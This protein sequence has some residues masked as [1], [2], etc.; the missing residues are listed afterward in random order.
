MKETSVPTVFSLQGGTAQMAYNGY[1]N[2]PHYPPGYEPPR[3]PQQQPVNLAQTSAIP[4]QSPVSQTPTNQYPNGT[5][6][7]HVSTPAF[8]AY[9]VDVGS[10]P[11]RPPAPPIISPPPPRNRK[12][13]SGRKIK[14]EQS[15]GHE[16]TEKQSGSG[17]VSP[18]TKEVSQLPP[19]KSQQ[20]PTG[21]PSHMIQEFTFMDVTI[22]APGQKSS[23]GKKGGDKD[24]KQAGSPPKAVAK[25]RKKQQGMLVDINHVGRDMAL[26]EQ[27]LKRRRVDGDEPI[28]D[29]EDIALQNF[30]IEAPVRTSLSGPSNEGGT[31][32][33]VSMKRPS[34]SEGARS[35]RRDHHAC[36]RCFRNKTKV[37]FLMEEANAKCSRAVDGKPPSKHFPCDYCVSIQGICSNAIAQAKK[38]ESV[39]LSDETH[40]KQ[41]KFKD[42]INSKVEQENL[43][44]RREL[45]GYEKK[46]TD[47][48]RLH[49]AVKAHN[50]TL[51]QNLTSVNA[52]LKGVVQQK[53][54]WQNRAMNLRR[55]IQNVPEDETDMPSVPPSIDFVEVLRIGDDPI[56]GAKYDTSLSRAIA[57]RDSNATSFENQTLETLETM[58]KDIQTYPDVLSAVTKEAPFREYKMPCV[59]MTQL[60]TYVRA[61]FAN[62]HPL[63]PVL[64]QE[65]FLRMYRTWAKDAL[66]DGI[67]SI[68]DAGRPGRAV[69]LIWSVAAL[70]A[71][72]L[73]ETRDR[74]S[75]TENHSA[76]SYSAHLQEALGLYRQCLKLL[77][78][79][80]ETIESMLAYLLVGVFAIQTMDPK[81][82]FRRLQNF[83]TQALS[84]NLSHALKEMRKKSDVSYDYDLWPDVT[85][86]IVIQMV[87]RAWCMF[88]SYLS[89]V[90]LELGLLSNIATDMEIDCVELLPQ[91]IDDEVRTSL[92]LVLTDRY[93]A[94][95]QRKNTVPLHIQAVSRILLPT[96]VLSKSWLVSETHTR[97]P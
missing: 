55:E 92:L 9:Q 96:C 59:D 95:T 16:V 56:P 48:A 60:H 61:Y 64:H 47:Q 5:N 52:I 53:T 51:E 49:E 25:G 63:L 90:A 11:V 71:L 35:G 62:V 6:I 1:P 43:D 97:L 73:V 32:T 26:A 89:S 81:E 93:V 91:E 70:G 12:S 80:R 14:K 66:G 54:Y 17:G 20:L 23:T 42:I 27:A 83:Q 4:A 87:A 78:H 30:S 82:A 74:E 29:S 3:Y 86:F 13:P 88:K 58:E 75:C 40:W 15:E 67:Q 44:L 31:E 69:C 33:K 65:A 21:P 77:I 18:H 7:H 38:P 39:S 45:D 2:Y 94:M 41:W 8:P 72:S 24:D 50:T 34:K 37:A 28:D 10:I 85:N 79:T 76:S 84:L 57:E 36:D 19:T 22:E 46:F 68:E